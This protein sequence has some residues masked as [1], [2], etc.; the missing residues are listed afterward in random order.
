MKHAITRTDALFE[1]PVQSIP[2]HS[3]NVI[4]EA[5]SGAVRTIAKD[6]GAA[7]IVALTESDF[8]SRLIS[9]HRPE[10]PILAINGS[11]SPP[12]WHD[13]LGGCL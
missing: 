2:F 4:T 7:A 1:G 9:K 5:I 10:C 13:D 6:L 3:A 11:A 8:T 12:S